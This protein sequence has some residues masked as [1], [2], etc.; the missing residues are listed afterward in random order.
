MTRTLTSKQLAALLGVTDR[1]VRWWASDLGCPHTREGRRY[2]FDEAEVR[3][4]QGSRP[5]A[6]LLGP[7][8]EQ[9]TA[10]HAAAPLASRDSLAKAELARKLTV[11]KRNELELAAERGLRDLDLGDRIRAAESHRDL[12]VISKEVGALLGTGALHPARGRAIQALLAEARHNLREHREVEGVEEPQRLLLVS[13][14]GAELLE[15][16]EWIVSEERRG[17]V[18]ALVKAEADADVAEDPH[19]DTAQGLDPD[20]VTEPPDDDFKLE[21]TP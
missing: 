21:E 13:E 10:A 9:G 2:L 3:A 1:T 20:A 4:W 11:A 8:P 12:A 5:Q 7:P 17:R 6:D 18:L 16:F 15:A 19:V 14:E